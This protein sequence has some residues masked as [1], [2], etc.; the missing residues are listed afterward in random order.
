MRSCPHCARPIE[1]WEAICH[2]CGGEV[3][4]AATPGP[5]SMVGPEDDPSLGIAAASTQTAQSV[6]STARVNPWLVAVLIASFF[7]GVTLMLMNRPSADLQGSPV[8][9]DAI[10]PAGGVSA[11]RR[12]SRPSPSSESSTTKWIGSRQPS[13]ASDGSRTVT[14]ELA[15][16][17]DVTVWMK[18]VRPVLVVRCLARN[19]DVYVVTKSAASIE[20][21]GDR[22]TVRVSFD[23][24]P[25]AAEQWFDS[26]DNQALF[27]PDGVALARQLAR[28]RVMHFG[29]TPYNASPVVAEF[30]VKGFDG[31]IRSVASV[32]GWKSTS[33]VG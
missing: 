5:T 7:L 20:R 1:E 10:D 9:V 27:S 22:H 8:T 28:A 19:T 11:S 15:A 21:N 17:N 12:S 4:E 3:T 24:S 23:E 14:F 29:F 16:E 13:W 2:S 26:V 18:R 32:C 25:E 33:Q 6:A 30:D 31:L